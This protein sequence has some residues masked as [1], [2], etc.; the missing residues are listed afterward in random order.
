MHGI[1]V[2]VDVFWLKTNLQYCYYLLYMDFKIYFTRFKVFERY[3]LSVYSAHE[4]TWMVRYLSY[5]VFSDIMETWYTV[6]VV[7]VYTK[8]S[9]KT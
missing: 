7:T 6:A 9:T 5:L 2:Q 4:N 1:Y 3:D 8:Y